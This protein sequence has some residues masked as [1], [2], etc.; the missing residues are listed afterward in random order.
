M[1]DAAYRFV[2][3]VVAE[4]GFNQKALSAVEFGAYDVNGNARA[5]FHHDTRWTGVDTR[6]GRGV[7]VVMPAEEYTPDRRVDVVLCTETLEHAPDWRGIVAAARRAL[8]AGGAFVVTAAGPGRTP[9]GCDGGDV[10]YEHYANIS[11]LDLAAALDE[12][13]FEDIAVEN[14]ERNHDVYAV[15]FAPKG[16]RR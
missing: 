12:A 7:D 11:P 4:H 2:S 9:H 10:G 1:H 13:G 16:K 3:G 15:A 8:K 14:N 6:A 5:L